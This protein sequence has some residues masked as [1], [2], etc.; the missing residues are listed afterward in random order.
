MS[1]DRCSSFTRRPSVVDSFSLGAGAVDG[2]L[3]RFSGAGANQASAAS[4]EAYA[5]GSK[6]AASSTLCIST[7]P[8]AAKRAGAEKNCRSRGM[9]RYGA[10][11]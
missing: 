11:K 4:G 3:W 9:R 5:P 6:S 10:V 2:A 1:G 7:Q 8:S